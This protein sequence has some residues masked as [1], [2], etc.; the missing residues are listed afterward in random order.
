MLHMCPHVSGTHY[1]FSRSKTLV[2]TWYQDKYHHSFPVP[3]FKGFSCKCP[4]DDCISYLFF[5]SKSLNWHFLAWH[6]P[7]LSQWSTARDW[8]LQGISNL[9]NRLIVACLKTAAGQLLKGSL[10]LILFQ[11]VPY[12]SFHLIVWTFLA[13]KS[14]AVGSSTD[15]LQY[16]MLLKVSPE[17]RHT[18]I[19]CSTQLHRSATGVTRVSW[20]WLL[21]VLF[22]VV[23]LFFWDPEASA[24]DNESERS[25][26]V[27]TLEVLMRDSSR[28]AISSPFPV[29]PLL[30]DLL[31]KKHVRV[32]IWWDGSL[33][34]RITREQKKE[35]LSSVG[36]SVGSRT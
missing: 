4:L 9:V 2:G 17:E 33:T 30:V 18:S 13:T 27:E 16:G 5:L 31:V 14:F 10:H 35:F 24:P 28:N 29:P 1:V 36:A 6:K 21:N 20:G 25:L 23:I 34:K 8:N 26:P 12:T 19:G 11:L 32:L 3:P 15:P 22:L 7:P